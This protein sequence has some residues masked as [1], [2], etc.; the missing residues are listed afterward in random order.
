[1]SPLSTY[2]IELRGDL[3]FEGPVEIVTLSFP[4]KTT[5]EEQCVF[6]RQ[7]QSCEGLGLKIVHGW[8][9][10]IGQRAS[11]VS[12]ERCESADPNSLQDRKPIRA[13]TA[14]EVSGDCYDGQGLHGVPNWQR[15]QYDTATES[16]KDCIVILN[17]RS[18]DQIYDV[19]RDGESWFN[20]CLV[21]LMNEASQGSKSA[22]YTTLREVSTT[23]ASCNVM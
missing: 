6:D 16:S 20:N 17:W 3:S 15:S 4:T 2:C 23:H 5:S 1:M 8:K 13:W 10:P 19:K 11:Y 21:P 22:L 9:R 12:K 18:L 14:S 7:M